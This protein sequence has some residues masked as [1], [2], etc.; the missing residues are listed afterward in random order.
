MFIETLLV[1]HYLLL[2]RLFKKYWKCNQTT[3]RSENNVELFDK[4]AVL[5]LAKLFR[6]SLA[7]I[8]CAVSFPQM[9]S[10]RYIYETRLLNSFHWNFYK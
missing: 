10:K 3:S 9:N 5:F 4:S 8:D 6:M 7:E 2:I 1:I